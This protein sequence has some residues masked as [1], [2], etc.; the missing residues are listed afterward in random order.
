MLTLPILCLASGQAPSPAPAPRVELSLAEAVE[1]FRRTGVDLLVAEASVDAARGGL[2]EDGALPAPAL[3]ASA[4]RT[5][6]GYDPAAAGPGASDRAY[7]LGISDSG[8]L[9]DLLWGRRSLRAR[10]ARAALEAARKGREDA[11]RTLLPALKGA[12]LQASLARLGV[13]LAERARDASRGTAD[14]VKV[15]RDAGAVSDAEMARARVGALEAERGLDASRQALAAAEAGL[16]FLLGYRDRAPAFALTTPFE[17]PDP[18]PAEGP[19]D[20]LKEALRRRPDLQAS[21]AQIDR[22]Q[23]GLALAHRAWAPDL[24]W[25]FGV[26][27]QGTGQFALQPRTFTLGLGVELPSP[28]RARGGIL[29]AEADLRTQELQMAKGEAQVVQDVTAASAALASARSR[30]GRMEGELLPSAREAFRL[31]SFQYQKGAAT[32]LDVLDA[33]RTL[34]AIQNEYLQDLGDFWSARFQMDQA[35]GKE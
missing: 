6:G 27:Q 17:H 18:G 10:A 21:R 13:D 2:L 11:A 25:S 15:Q 7:S 34:V 30:L 26:S 35:L 9:A 22:A 12:Y 24:T 23:A 33:Q 20:L 32:L 31:V 14:L 8:A 16:A 3:S 19:G 4:G 1:R 5:R 28:A 29:R